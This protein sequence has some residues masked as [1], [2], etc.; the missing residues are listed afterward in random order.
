MRPL[1][2]AHRRK[3]LRARE[4]ARTCL[5][6]RERLR[7]LGLVCELMQLCRSAW[8]VSPSLSVMPRTLIPPRG[9]CQC[10]ALGATGCWRSLK[11]CKA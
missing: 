6:Q 9:C 11:L 10:T 2:R 8:Q 3:I 5:F 4:S 7:G 1:T